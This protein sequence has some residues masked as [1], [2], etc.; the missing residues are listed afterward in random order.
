MALSNFDTRIMKVVQVTNHQGDVRYRMLRGI[1]CSC[2]SLMSVCWTL[3]KSASIWDSFDLDCIL[4]KRDLWFKSLN[5]YRYIGMEDLRQEFFIENSSINV[6]FLNN[7]TGEITAGEYLVSITEIV[8]DCQQ[9]GA[10]AQ[11]IINNYI[12]GLLWGNQYFFLFYS[13]SKDEIRRMSATGTAALQ[14]SLLPST[15]F[16][17]KMH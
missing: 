3:Y 9:I 4:R 5:N 12:L 13:H 14:L 7:R 10:G 17:T 16:K 11:L 6:E 8:S 1:Q 15:V 2:M